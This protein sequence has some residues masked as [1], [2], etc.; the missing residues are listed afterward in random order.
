MNDCPSV[1]S[2]IYRR[3]MA[4]NPSAWENL[5]TTALQGAGPL[6]ESID[7]VFDNELLEAGGEYGIP[8][9][10]DPVQIDW[11]QITHGRGTTEITVYNRAIMLFHTENQIYPRMHRLCSGIERQAGQ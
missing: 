10:G 11:L 1:H 9:A 2:T 3:G 8:D 5:N 6:Q 4:A 7:A